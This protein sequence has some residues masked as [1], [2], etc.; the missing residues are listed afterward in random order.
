M[1]N[2][3]PKDR[4]IVW[5]RLPDSE[6]GK[7]VTIRKVDGTV[8]VV[9]EYFTQRHAD[10]SRS[11]M[12]VEE[13]NAMLMATI[14]RN[15]GLAAD[16]SMTVKLTYNDPLDTGRSLLV[17]ETK[18]I[19]T[20]V[21]GKLNDIQLGGRQREYILLQLIIQA[22]YI[23][24]SGK[25]FKDYGRLKN[26][27]IKKVANRST[28]A[29]RYDFPVG[30]RG[31]FGGTRKVVLRPKYIPIMLDYANLGESKSL[32]PIADFDKMLEPIINYDPKLGE[33]F[34]TEEIRHRLKY[35]IAP[36]RRRRAEKEWDEEVANVLGECA[37]VMGFKDDGDA[38][39]SERR[40][41]WLMIWAVMTCLALALAL[42]SSTF[43]MARPEV[44]TT[45]TAANGQPLPTSRTHQVF[46]RPTMKHSQVNTLAK[47]SR[48]G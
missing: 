4:T 38:T 43:T 27:A 36:V 41:M 3:D 44:G 17:L 15:M 2:I 46:K 23:A 16:F 45:K 29:R 34:I 28:P 1:L 26:V 42:G 10:K 5:G 31:A 40:D 47:K 48:V 11:D 12:K 9:K 32:D 13:E 6:F 22:Y 20:F 19:D 37:N 24:K 30:Q 18:C 21:D 25:T 35:S 33:K 39:P 7:V 8:Y 14:F